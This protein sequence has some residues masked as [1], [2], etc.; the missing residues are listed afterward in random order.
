MK[1][2]FRELENFGVKLLTPFSFSITVLMNSYESDHFAAFITWNFW[3][4]ARLVHI[5][6]NK[7]VAEK[8]W[9]FASDEKSWHLKSSN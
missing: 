4:Y 8:N 2:R 5:G 3:F 6:K 7:K 1:N 9:S